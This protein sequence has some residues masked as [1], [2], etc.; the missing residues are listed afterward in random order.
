MDFWKSKE[1]RL[2]H[3]IEQA[4]AR[5]GTNV[6]NKLGRGD[7]PEQVRPL[8]IELLELLYKQR[9]SRTTMG[10][11]LD[12]LMTPMITAIEA[13]QGREKADEF[14]SLLARFSAEARRLSGERVQ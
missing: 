4:L 6:R 1:W 8:S 7:A 10:D 13:T 3:R 5:E 12:A 14:D 11:A 2:W 9:T